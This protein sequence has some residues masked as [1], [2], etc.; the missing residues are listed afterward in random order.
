MAVA[1]ID[2][3]AGNLR[4]AA[5]A[6]QAAGAERV[7]V[8]ND[9]AVVRAADRIVLPGVGAFGACV[10]ALR[11]IDGLE[12]ALNEAVHQR[13]VPFLGICVGMQLMSDEGHEFGVHRGLGWVQ[14]SVRRMEPGGELKIPQIGWN[15]VEPRA[16]SLIEPGYAYFVHS[17]ALQAAD[18][19]DI[20]GTAS[21]GAPI[22][23]AVQ[24]ANMLGCQF[25]PEKSQGYGLRLLRRWL[26]WKP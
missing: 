13:A 25:H 20:A 24:R 7:D 8:S 5:N 10:S 16:G 15:E 22:V 2:Y 19:A 21:Y 14:G 12:E 26:A 1:L 23:A 9:P 6:L 17:Y 18:P 4:S 11:A 3:G